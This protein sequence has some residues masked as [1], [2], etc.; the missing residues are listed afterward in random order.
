MLKKTIIFLTFVSLLLCF[1]KCARFG[2]SATGDPQPDKV[3]KEECIILT[4]AYVDAL[5]KQP[6]PPAPELYDD[7]LLIAILGCIIDEE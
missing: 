5:F 6:S 2:I 1:N 3:S 4:T 7:Y